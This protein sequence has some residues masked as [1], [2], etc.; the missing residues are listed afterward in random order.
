MKKPQQKLKLS[1][2]QTEHIIK[3]LQSRFLKNEALQKKI[4]WETIYKR[5]IASPQKLWSISEMENSGGEPDL[6]DYNEKTGEC[7]FMDCVAESPSGRRSIC[8]DREGLDSRKE[9]KPG[10]N[11]I[12]MAGEM[13]IEMLNEEQ[14]KKFNALGKFDNKTSSWLKTDDQTDRK[15]TR[16]NSSH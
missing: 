9:F 12:D 5:L 11:A 15:S 7:M 4:K 3:L 16:L 13:G 8:Y 6:V 10:G 14:Y 1:P 2:S